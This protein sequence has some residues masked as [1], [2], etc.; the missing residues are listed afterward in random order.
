MSFT[1]SIFFLFKK[2]VIEY[3]ILQLI[4]KNSNF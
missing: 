4:K 1:K 2:N 3:K